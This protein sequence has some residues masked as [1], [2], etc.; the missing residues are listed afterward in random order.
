MFASLYVCRPLLNGAEVAAWFA[1]QGLRS[2]VA[3]DSMHCT[4]L[5]S[6]QTMN[7]NRVAPDETELVVEPMRGA[8]GMGAY[9]VDRRV[10]RLGDQGAIV[11]RLGS[12][13]SNEGVRRLIAR[14]AEYRA[15]GGSS[16]YPTYLPHITISF[17]SEGV[18]IAALKPFPGAL[19]FGPE[20]R[21]EITSDWKPN[22]SKE[23]PVDI[24]DKAVVAR[25]PVII[26]SKQESGGRR[27]V[28]VEASCSR[29]DDG[30]PVI[31]YDGDHIMQEALLKSAESFVRIGHLD[32]DHLS[33]F[34]ER[35]G[36]ADPASYVVG[37]PLEVT[38]TPDGRTIVLGEISK[39]L[40]GVDV[41]RN[42][43]DEFWMSL[44]RSPPVT[45][46]SSVYGFPT[47]MVDCSAG[48]CGGI[49]RYLIKAMDW[50]SLAFTRTPKNESVK[51]AAT[52]VT[53]K[54][55]LIELAKGLAQGPSGAPP[56]ILPNSMDGVFTAAACPNCEVA[57]APSLLGY[58]SH[59]TVCK[60]MAPGVA[61]VC[62]HAL[63]HAHNMKR[64]LA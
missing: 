16:D 49:T 8:R 36:I 38:G 3:S 51:G 45:W 63:M 30:S 1:P 2:L 34:G 54:A 55:H 39:A 17:N 46:Y 22:L 60:G 64:A 25:I 7:W 42:K 48:T 41:T 5:Y 14:E 6:K 59:F 24:L 35:L 57:K 32:I 18:D 21:R 56:I 28:S 52:I 9:A 10:E 50:R 12:E 58:R 61:D 40:D 29:N 13:S 19:R 20:R 62:A 47:D 15:A 23:I 44:R 37:R 27:L 11:L 43:Y 31:D 33:E 53:A 26:K 4:I